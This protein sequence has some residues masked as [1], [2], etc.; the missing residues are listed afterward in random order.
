MPQDRSSSYGTNNLFDTS[1]YY[2]YY[3]YF[4]GRLN[5]SAVSC[6][7]DAACHLGCDITIRK[8]TAVKEVSHDSNVMSKKLSNADPKGKGKVTPIPANN[9]EFPSI[10]KNSL[11]DKS[12]DD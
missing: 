5:E 2:N 9:V 8:S 6:D 11:L 12:I 1:N 3:N 7:D 4:S 10:G